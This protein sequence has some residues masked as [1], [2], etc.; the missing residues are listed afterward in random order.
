MN[1]IREGS[2]GEEVRLLQLALQRL[3]YLPGRPDGIFGPA[4]AAAVIRFQQ[5]YGH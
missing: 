2:R 3:G 1:T 4:T 5:D